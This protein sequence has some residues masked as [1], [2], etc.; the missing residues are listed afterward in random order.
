MEY[1]KDYLAK[2]FLK[3]IFFDK[4]GNRILKE[5]QSHFDAQ[6]L[7]PNKI[8][9]EFENSS[10]LYDTIFWGKIVSI[11]NSCFNT[12]IN[13]TNYNLNNEDEFKNFVQE[14][15]RIKFDFIFE[16]DES[17]KINDK[18]LLDEYITTLLQ[19]K[20]VISIASQDGIKRLIVPSKKEYSINALPNEP[21]TLVAFPNILIKIDKQRISFNCSNK[22]RLSSIIKKIQSTSKEGDQTILG[23]FNEE[24]I[25]N[26]NVDVKNFFT[27]LKEEGFFIKTIRFRSPLFY[28]SAGSKD[29]LDYEKL[30]D[31][32]FYLNTILDFINIQQIKMVFNQNVGNKSKD[33]I[34][35]IKIICHELSE[36]AGTIKFNIVISKNKALTTKI[37][38]EISNKLKTIGIVADCSY[39]LP[40]EYY[41]NKFL[42][43]DGSLNKLYKKIL[44]LDKDNKILNELIK[45]QI[46]S[47][48]EEIKVNNDK[49]N[50]F[51]LTSF[52]KLIKKSYSSNNEEFT[53]SDV[54]MDDKKR[55][56]LN[57]KISNDTLLKNEYY[58][59]IVDNDVRGY[60]R[61]IKIALYNF[62]RA[63]FLKSILEGNNEKVLS[64]LYN[65]I[66]SYLNYEY[67]LQLEK[68]AKSAHS[69]LKEYSSNFK[70][71]EKNKNPTQLGGIVEKKLNILMKYLYRNYLL[72][73]GPLKPDGYL[74]QNKTDTYLI[75]SKQHK[76]I[77]IGE[78]DKIVRYLFSFCK[79]ARLP[80]SNNGILIICREKLG[81][82][83]NKKSRD[84]WKNS[85]EYNKKYRVAFVSLEFLLG[86]FELVR[87]PVVNANNQLKNKIQ[88]A[89][90]E[91]IKQ[92]ADFSDKKTLT[93]L[94]DKTMVGLQ[95]EIQRDDYIPQESKEL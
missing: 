66:W 56:I 53:I 85:K 30:V 33:F 29:V 84:E 93:D 89:F 71:L 24:T 58:Q 72:I 74:Y 57:I 41:L 18:K 86:L 52:K 1:T 95:K 82:T 69:W 6:N 10:N 8:L 39:E 43:L 62:D 23:E 47:N 16:C 42:Y 14:L 92:S 35:T 19:N 64:Y 59:V 7:S 17:K 88:D 31:A 61:I 45:S 49:L 90:Y 80:E 25:D 54:S 3:P 51:I 32:N 15:L 28:F 55:I 75:D 44:S 38:K 78:I 27:N 13:I 73:G 83:L 94:E 12:N 70:N 2:K 91:V 76:D 87:K 37:E 77:Y 65:R 11:I 5:M 26:L 48:G 20:D 46:V 40:L 67:N 81:K 34:V 50:E 63:Y 68:E 21:K 36:E 4:D 60:D 9:T 79:K 22:A